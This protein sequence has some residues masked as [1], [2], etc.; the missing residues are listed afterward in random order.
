MAMGRRGSMYPRM[1]SQPDRGVVY[2]LCKNALSR[3]LAISVAEN[4]VMNDSPNTVMP[5][6]RESI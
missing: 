3:S 2:S 1:K 5:G 4:R 6:V